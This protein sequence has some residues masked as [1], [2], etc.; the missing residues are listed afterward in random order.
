MASKQG[1]QPPL[2]ILVVEDD[3]LF[4]KIMGSVIP[5]KFPGITFNTAVNGT[6]GLQ[7]FKEHTPD[8][9][10]TDINMPEMDGIQMAQAIKSIKDDVRFIVLSGYSDTT[11]LEKISALGAHG[12][13]VKPVDLGKLFAMIEKCIDEIKL[14][15][16]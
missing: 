2:S 7:L 9:V 12:S 15:R 1:S 4:N 11:Y 5:M 14:Q 16:Q 10:I 8:I 6:S 13:L 3:T